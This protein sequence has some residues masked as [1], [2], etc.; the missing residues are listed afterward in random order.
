MDMMKRNARTAGMQYLRLV[1]VATLRLACNK[2]FIAC[3]LMVGARGRLRT[4][5]QL[6][7]PGAVA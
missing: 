6:A 4:S 2:V 3:R 1:L 5:R 7:V